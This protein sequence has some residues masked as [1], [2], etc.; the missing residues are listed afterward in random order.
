MAN[1]I[2]YLMSGSTLI[3][4]ILSI[5]VS[6]MNTAKYTVAQHRMFLGGFLVFGFLAWLFAYLGGI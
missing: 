3:F 1:F 2:A 6:I 5:L 4:A